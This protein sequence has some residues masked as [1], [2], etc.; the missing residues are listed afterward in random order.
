[1]EIELFTKSQDSS[2]TEFSNAPVVKS[3][4]KQVDQIVP[5][6][7]FLTEILVSLLQRNTVD[8]DARFAYEEE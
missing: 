1:M 5:L 8:R 4:L 3:H 2:A 6:I 7:F